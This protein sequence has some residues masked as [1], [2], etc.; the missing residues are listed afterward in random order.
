[1]SKYNAGM[2]E[3]GM[4]PGDL[5]AFKKEAGRTKLYFGGGGSGGG[6]TTQS[7]GTTYQTNLPEYARPY[8]ET[9]LGATQQQLF[10]TEQTPSGDI[11]ITGFRPY[12]PYSTNM[13]DYVAPFSPMQQRAMA[14]TQNLQL[15]EQYYPA[16]DV[17]AQAA[18]GSLQ[19]APQAQ[20]LAGEALGYGGQGAGYGAQA[21][22]YGAQGA[23]Q[24]ARGAEQGARMAGMYGTQ[25][26]MTGREAL[27]YGAEAAGYGTQ[28]ALASQ[29]GFGAGA[30]Y[31]QQA[32]TPSSIQAYMSPYMQNVVDYQKSQ[33]ARDYA[34]GQQA[35]KA[36]AVGQ[37]AFGGS[38]QAIVEAEAQRTL[39]N[40]LAG[41]EAQG[42]QQAF[43]N[44]QQAQ[45]FGANLGLQGLQAGYQG[46]GMGIQGAQAGLQGVA[47]AQNAAQ[48]GL[49]GVAQQ[50]AARQLGLAGT[51]QGIQGAQ[52]GM[53]G[54]QTGLQGVQGAVGAGQY[55]LAGLGQGIQ[56]AQA[57]GQLGTQQL[58]AEQGI[59][60]AQYQ[61]GTQQ[62]AMEQQ[63]INQAIQ[64]Y[65]T[66]QQYPL[67]QLGFMSNMLRGLPMQSTSTNQYVAAPNYLTQ[68]VGAVGTG[69]SLY[70][71][72]KAKGGIVDSKKM[73]SGG[74]ASYSVG[75]NVESILDD[76][77]P[78]QLRQEMKE[79]SSDSVRKMAARMLQEKKAGGGIV[80]FSEG[81]PPPDEEKKDY[82]NEPSATP[83]QMAAIRTKEEP[84]APPA[85]PAPAAPAPTGILQAQDPVAL[86]A[87]KSLQ[88]APLPGYLKNVN[89][90]LLQD[91]LKTDE[92]RMEEQKALRE[93]YVGPNVAAQEYRQQV[94]AERANAAQEAERQRWMRAAEFFSG[95]GST[96]GPTI[97][98]GLM[99]MKKVVPDLIKD[100]DQAKKYKR[101]L[102]KAIY[103]LDNADRMEKLGDLEGMKKEKDK[104]MDRTKT[105]IASMN[106][107]YKEQQQTARTA[108]T[109]GGKESADDKALN[110]ADKEVERRI[111]AEKNRLAIKER[112]GTLTGED[113]QY[114]DRLEQSVR[115][116]VYRDRG[117]KIPE[118]P[119]NAP[120][121]PEV[122]AEERQKAE[123]TIKDNTPGI[124][125][126]DTPEKKAK[127]EAAQRVLDGMSG[128]SDNDRKPL[129]SFDKDK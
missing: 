36:Q 58:A 96:P 67:M 103:D 49:Q 83:E 6:G 23:M 59:L 40:Q 65:A 84:P 76:M 11:S 79:T 44:A 75:G 31:A 115:D 30:Q 119:A 41:I 16:S 118:A 13:Q 20:A 12:T 56:G 77:T 10:N 110:N 98:A 71:A 126:K 89:A 52:A 78:D 92:Q 18:Y 125:G 3:A 29:Q 87:Q 68:A 88:Q 37:G 97:A 66:A 114:L 42:A 1:M 127:R 25:G 80:A 120:K 62:Q 9:M 45:Q 19:A 46:L 91:A 102:D 129:S 106:D 105:V 26:A 14:G 63:K 47:G 7:T 53:Q 64:D 101:E 117:I 48:T 111:K 15:P 32:T 107:A 50:L 123:K 109:A 55:G 121:R 74:I 21:S 28:G 99:S 73:A 72:L 69:A 27:G 90:A 43:Q 113:L 104:A 38:R 2:L 5:G 4:I 22:G 35:R 24:A 112:Q 54:A 108:M 122:I 85:A 57:L 94:M 81:T 100:T 70:N 95:W 33:A 86:A 51:A 128:S 124:F 93:K 61:M 34:I 39:G 8:V 60:G 17:A 116:Q 82:S